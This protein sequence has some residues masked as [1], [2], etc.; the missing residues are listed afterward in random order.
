MKQLTGR[1]NYSEYWVFRGW[2]D[3][4]SYDADWFNNGREGPVI[5]DPQIV[6]DVPYNAV[7]TAGFYCVKTN[8]L[9]AADGGATEK[10]SAAVTKLV[11]PYERPPAPRRLNETLLSY[12]ILNDEK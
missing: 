9:K 7:D 2:L 3:R 12:R 5:D 8:I 1:Y 11:N 4:N 6:A 10:A